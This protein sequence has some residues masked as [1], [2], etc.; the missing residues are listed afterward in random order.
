[1]ET[2]SKIFFSELNKKQKLKFDIFWEKQKPRGR[3]KGFIFSWF[4]GFS[5]IRI[6]KKSTTSTHQLTA[7]TK[8]KRCLKQQ[9]RQHEKNALRLVDT[10]TAWPKD[11]GFGFVLLSLRKRQNITKN[12]PG[13]ALFL[14]RLRSYFVRVGSQCD[15]IGKFGQFLQTFY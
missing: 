11:I 5:E 4:P 1:M 6:D 3:F 12:W 9:H 8:T 15:Q 2:V 10:L 13:I 14:K 7:K